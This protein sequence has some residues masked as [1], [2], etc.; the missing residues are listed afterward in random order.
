MR[1]IPFISGLLTICCQTA[2]MSNWAISLLDV[3]IDAYLT[4]HVRGSTLWQLKGECVCF[5]Y[6]HASEFSGSILNRSARHKRRLWVCHGMSNVTQNTLN[7]AN[8]N[9]GKKSHFANFSK[10]Y[11]TIQQMRSLAPTNIYIFVIRECT[12]LCSVY[13]ST[14]PIQRLSPSQHS[15]SRWNF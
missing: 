6:F 7:I 2:V 11:C 12:G 1:S 10:R 5:Y 3:T 15:L 4:P 13:V 8:C 9:N 14:T